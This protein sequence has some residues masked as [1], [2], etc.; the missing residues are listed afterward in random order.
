MTE[1]SHKKPK[2]KTDLELSPLPNQHKRFPGGQRVEVHG[3]VHHIQGEHH[4]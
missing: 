1:G 3:A 4:N 2:R